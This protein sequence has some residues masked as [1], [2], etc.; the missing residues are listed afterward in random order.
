VGSVGI[1]E[2]D[3]IHSFGQPL[4]A[5]SQRGLVR[6][7][8]AL[9]GEP[10]VRH[11]V[12]DVEVLLYGDRGAVRREELFLDL[13]DGVDRSESGLLTPDDLVGPEREHRG[14]AVGAERDQDVPAVARV[15]KR[16]CHA[17]WD[18]GRA[19]SAVD[20]QIQLR[21]V[22]DVP[23]VVEERGLTASSSSCAGAGGLSPVTNAITRLSLICS[24]F[25][26][27]ALRSA[28]GMAHLALVGEEG[29]RPA[30]EWV[31]GH[32]CPP[33]GSIGASPPGPWFISVR[34]QTESAGV[35][36]AFRAE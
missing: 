3:R 27:K 33:P 21:D 7:S 13:E 29:R 35:V 8:G 23:E 10:A 18:V 17:P 20:E 24:I 31:E 19:T 36:S 12:L 34:E 5:L 15:P 28:C 30:R 14:C 2:R 16:G 22:A 11:D 4:E 6:D 9:A 26:I 32:G 25:S 1:A